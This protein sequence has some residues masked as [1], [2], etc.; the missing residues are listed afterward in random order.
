MTTK[1]STRRS[2]IQTTGA[3]LSVPLAAAAAIVPARAA[4]G[5]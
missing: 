3:A 2:F 5:G 1:P 4:T